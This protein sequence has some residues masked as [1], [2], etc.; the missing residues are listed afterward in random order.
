MTRAAYSRTSS[1][2]TY[3][4]LKICKIRVPRFSNYPDQTSR[5][6]VHFRLLSHS[7]AKPLQD[8]K[9]HLH[10]SHKHF[11]EAASGGRSRG[12]DDD[13]GRLEERSLS[14]FGAPRDILHRQDQELRMEDYANKKHHQVRRRT[15][16]GHLRSSSIRS[17]KTG[18]R[19][20]RL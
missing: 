16:I 15:R 12:E 6:L 18:T 10:V 19:I 2:F 11:N 20:L 3:I 8:K 7:R 1:S 5:L 4:T 9:R 14:R 13:G 17:L